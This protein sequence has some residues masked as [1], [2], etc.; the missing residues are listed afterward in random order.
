MT[1]LT[2][3]WY[4]NHPVDSLPPNITHLVF[5]LYFN[6]PIDSLPENIS[7]LRFGEQF[8][9]PFNIIYD[10]LHEITFYKEYQYLKEF[11]ELYKNR[12][13]KINIVNDINNII[14]KYVI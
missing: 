1:H 6:Q 10:N 2:F 9:R 13:V 5:G 7:S 4:F 8:N 14:K 3:G 12:N 11:E